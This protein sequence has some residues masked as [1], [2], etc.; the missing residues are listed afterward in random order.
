VRPR[1]RGLRIAF[2]R[3]RAGAVTV[4]VVRHARGRR[5]S[6]PRRVASLRHVRS[7]R[8]WR[9]KGVRDGWYTARVRL[10]HDVRTF[11]L[12]RRDGRFH[13][14]GPSARHPGCG[15]VR[16]FALSAPV[17]GGRTARRLTATVR[18]AP[19]RHGRLELR[20]GG[21]TLR[22][23]RVA[24]RRR[25]RIRATGLARGDYRVRI[26]AHGVRRT[27]VARRL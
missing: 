14:R 23:V 18:L 16:R 1:G 20:R 2:A 6:A 3:A 21:R 17:F 10:R 11:A 9:A 13:R 27:L 5:A 26:V 24:G 22:H 7:G 8:V 15:T 19:G 4:D 12:R 25:W